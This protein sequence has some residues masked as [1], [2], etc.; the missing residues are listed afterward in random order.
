[1]ASCPC[2][3]MRAHVRPHE[4][5]HT[6]P[7]TRARTQGE[8]DLVPT[9]DMLDCDLLG[10]DGTFDYL[11]GSDDKEPTARPRGGSCASPFSPGGVSAETSREVWSSGGLSRLS[12]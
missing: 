9:H 7:C 12:S 1:M 4:R 3:P 11:V 8:S 2:A 5:A 10:S 6:S